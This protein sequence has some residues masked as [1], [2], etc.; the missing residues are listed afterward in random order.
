MD[1]NDKILVT[2]GT[3]F[4]G[5]YIIRELVS[6]G[7]QNIHALRRKSSDMRM[8]E[9]FR[10]S[11]KWH[12]ADLL[13]IDDIYNLVRGSARVIHAAGLVSFAPKDKELLYEINIQGTENIVNA[14]LHHQVPRLIHLS[15]IAAIAKTRKG[16]PISEETKWVDS[17][18]ISHYGRSKHLGETEVWRGVAEGLEAVILNPSVIL[19]AGDWYASSCRLFMKIKEGLKYYPPGS[20]GFVDVRD[21][22]YIATK[23][24]TH[25]SINQRFIINESNYNFKDIFSWMAHHL[26]VKP[27]HIS[28]PRWVA[29]L[30]VFLESIKSKATGTRPV[31][32]PDS[33]RNSYEDFHYDNQKIKSL[34]FSFIPIEKTIQETC[35]LL[36]EAAKDGFTPI[37]L[38]E[39]PAL[40]SNSDT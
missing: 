19:G 26:D 11:V 10:T 31:I 3:G 15:S 18:H 36:Q 14:C 5:A 27:P 24:I 4:V 29:K 12:I 2:G 22:A 9:P 33:V 25:T 30:I 23:M 32:T 40:K 34:G 28:A 35:H 39:K 1:K 8:V 13:D 20:T 17:H 16:K 37:L 21:V 38:E 7:Y 6:Q